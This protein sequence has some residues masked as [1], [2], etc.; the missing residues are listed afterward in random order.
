VIVS[1]AEKENNVKTEIRIFVF[2]ALVLPG[3]SCKDRISNTGNERNVTFSYLSSK[4]LLHG[5]AKG[6]A[7]DSVFEYS[8]RQDL[9]MDFSAWSNCCPDSER[10]VLSH[11]IYADT[12][13]ITVLDTVAHLCNCVCPYT[14]HVELAD[15]PFDQ[16]I[17]RCRIGV[18]QTYDDPIHLIAVR[19]NG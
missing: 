18:G 1:Q 13:L 6:S 7:L 14:L 15:L 11:A 12:I 5:L 3:L 19:R 16:Y 17:V 9:I 4:C 8:F 10:F 2:I